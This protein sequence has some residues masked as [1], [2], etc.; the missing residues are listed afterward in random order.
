MNTT[1][2]D[3]APDGGT[4]SA[5]E[6]EA[7]AELRFHSAPDGS[8]RANITVKGALHPALAVPP[9]AQALRHSRELVFHAPPVTEKRPAVG[10]ALAVPLAVALDVV[11][12]PLQLLGFAVVLVLVA[13]SR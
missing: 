11:T 7:L 6:I 8:Q 3:L 9:Q 1:H 10:N 2:E 12:A 4:F 13:T 5:G